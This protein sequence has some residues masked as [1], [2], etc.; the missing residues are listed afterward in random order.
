MKKSVAR[1]NLTEESAPPAQSLPRSGNLKRRLAGG[2]VSVGS[3]LQLAHP[4][5]AEIMAD[6]GFEWLVIDLEH[7][8]ITIREAEELVRIAGLSGIVPLVRV[9]SNDPVQI[10]RVMDA[11]AGGIVVPM[12]KTR[13]EA[14]RAVG[15]VRYPP[16]GYRGVGL[17]RA[18]GYGARF[19]EYCKWLEEESIVIVQIEHIEAVRNLSAIFQVSGVDGFIVGVY[20]LSGSLGVPGQFDHPLMRAALAEI[21]HRAAEHPGIIPGFH[22]VPQRPELVAEKVAEG[23][24]LIAYSSDMLLLGEACRS[25]VRAMKA[26]GAWGRALPP[27]ARP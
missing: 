5:H 14:E 16:T 24:R 13:E 9:S 12:V 26:I 4:A 20:D 22:V 10:K 6:A 15:A 23:Y 17:A 19:D 11:G 27:P 7:S 18:Q 3:W 1:S 2:E 25:G 21:K 8:V